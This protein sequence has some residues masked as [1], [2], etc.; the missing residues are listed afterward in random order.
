MMPVAYHADTGVTKSL[1]ATYRIVAFRA[2]AR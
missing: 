2:A 1:R